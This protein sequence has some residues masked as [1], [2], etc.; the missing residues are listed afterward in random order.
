MS[1][2][3]GDRVCVLG[4]GLIGGSV[5][6]AAAAAG[7]QVTGWNRG[8]VDSPQVSTDLPAVLTAAGDDDALVLLAVPM[9]ALEPVLAA[10]AEHAPGCALTDVVSVKAPV[11]DAVARRGLGARYVGGHPMAGTSRSGWD[12]GHAELFRDAAWVVAADDGLDADV[13]RRVARLALDCG[14]HVVPAAATEHD[15]AVARISH[16]PHLMAAVLASVG[17]DGGALA[18][19]L[20]AGSFTDG[21]RVAGTRPELTRAMLEANG[22]ALREALDDALGRLGA[23]RGALTSTGSVGATI[24]DGHDARALFVDHER[25]DITGVALHDLRALREAGRAGGVLRTLD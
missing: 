23:A 4:A 2:T 21:T 16:L 24:I 22:P 14:A 18:M 1:V 3:V 19:G 20:G 17:A 13:W 9:T 10:V 7:W 15:A 8:P 6:R 11:V 5:I 25:F 12:A